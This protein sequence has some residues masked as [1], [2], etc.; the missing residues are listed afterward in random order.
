MGR[1]VLGKVIG[2]V[3]CLLF[4]CFKEEEEEEE[5]NC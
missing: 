3:C 5:L 2:V 4:R 1:F